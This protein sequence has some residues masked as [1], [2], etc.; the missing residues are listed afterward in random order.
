MGLQELYTKIE[1]IIPDNLEV[2]FD[3]TNT[4]IIIW[5]IDSPIIYIEEDYITL[6]KIEFTSLAREL[7]DELDIQSI[8][9]N[10]E[11]EYETF[12]ERRE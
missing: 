3:D 12:Y 11:N 1:E 4:R 8:R 9:D 2:A 10:C 6:N 7:S 5:N